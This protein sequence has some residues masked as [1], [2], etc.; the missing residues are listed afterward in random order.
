MREYS[1]SRPLLQIHPVQRHPQKSN[2]SRNTQKLK[3]KENRLRRIIR[4]ALPQ[5]GL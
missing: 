5:N 3:G 1:D 4:T 2:T